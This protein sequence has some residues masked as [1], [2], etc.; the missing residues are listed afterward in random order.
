MKIEFS[1]Q[2]FENAQILNSMN[3]RPVGAQLFQTDRFD[4][5]TSRFS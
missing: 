4:E 2:V 5:A 1:R 3:I